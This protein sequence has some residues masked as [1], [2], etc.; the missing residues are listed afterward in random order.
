MPYTLFRTN[1]VTLTSIADGTL[2]LTTDLK[3]VGKNYAGYGQ[4]VNEN[5]VRLLENFSN[6]SPP[7]KPITG[8]LWYDSASKRLKVYD[9]VRWNNVLQS[10]TSSDEPTDLAE[11]DFWFDKFS[12]LLYIKSAG[13]LLLIGP[14]AG[15]GNESG[16]GTLATTQILSDS[17]ITYNII[18]LMIADQTVAILSNYEFTVAASH[19]LSS[20]FT[21]IKKGVTLKTADNI[22]GISTSQ[23]Y[24]FW[25]TAADSKRLNGS[26]ASNYVLASSI[27]SLLTNIT[28][29]GN[30]TRISTGSPVIPGTIEG[31]WTLIAGSTLQA[32]YADIAE[33]YHADAEYAPGTVLVIGGRY[34]VTICSTSADV[35]VAGIVS[36]KP[37]F[38]MNQD[39]GTDLTHPYLA[40]KG[41]LPCQVVGRVHKGDLLVTSSVPG[42]GRSFD[43]S[44]SP[45]AVFAK[46]LQSH[47]SDG[48]GVIEVMVA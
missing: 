35:A 18:K 34:D 24:W 11:G 17:D 23:D 19:P 29:L 3:L 1:G 6:I 43:K 41:R 46:A 30:I 36:E 26:P 32:T 33:R 42:H 13:K 22:T 37:A 14:N 31:A 38:K 8:Q 47:H 10:S 20:E 27:P 12:Q 28:E 9:G 45:N 16:S 40:L 21:K 15:S 5:L 39:A 4:V 44:D 7:G 2:N 48:Q 25:G